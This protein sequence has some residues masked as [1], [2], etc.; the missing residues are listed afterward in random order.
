MNVV[1]S[2]RLVVL[3]KS[4]DFLKIRVQEWLVALIYLYFESLMIFT[5]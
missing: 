3:A 1:I 2:G 5:R 4:L